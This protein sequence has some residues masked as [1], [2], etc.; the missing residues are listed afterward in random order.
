MMLLC[1]L[2]SLNVLVIVAVD[3]IVD[4]VGQGATRQLALRNKSTDCCRKAATGVNYITAPSPQTVR[5]RGG[6]NDDDKDDDG[7]HNV[8]LPA[9]LSSL[10][11]RV[12]TPRQA[13]APV[14]RL[15]TLKSAHLTPATRRQVL[16]HFGGDVDTSPHLS[17]TT[18]KHDRIESE[19]MSKGGRDEYC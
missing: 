8:R 3:D 18:N 14:P 6:G 7:G 10:E 13:V 15:E 5:A 4:A 2:L 12:P 9:G 11:Q 16:D 19:K 17:Y 1:L